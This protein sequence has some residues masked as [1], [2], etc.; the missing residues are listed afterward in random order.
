MEELNSGDRAIYEVLGEELPFVAERRGLQN[1]FRGAWF[2]IMNQRKEEV[3][4]FCNSEPSVRRE[5]SVIDTLPSIGTPS[6]SQVTNS[7]KK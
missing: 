6:I 1:H 5:L 3:R 7:G 4:P 2:D